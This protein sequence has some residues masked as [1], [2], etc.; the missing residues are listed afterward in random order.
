MNK[1]SN[2][3]LLAT[4]I[5]TDLI[6]KKYPSDLDKLGFSEEEKERIIFNVTNKAKRKERMMLKKQLNK[7]KAWQAL[8]NSQKGN[9]KKNN[10]THI[11][12]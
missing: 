4:N 10:Y 6:K 8:I 2:I 11:G 1:L 9:Q 7:E 5:A 12:C 3:K